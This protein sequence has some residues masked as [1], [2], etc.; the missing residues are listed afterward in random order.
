MFAFENQPAKDACQ[1]RYLVTADMSLL[2]DVQTRGNEGCLHLQGS[3]PKPAWRLS[4]AVPFCFCLFFKVTPCS[5]V[6]SSGDDRFSSCKYAPAGYNDYG[7]QNVVTIC[8]H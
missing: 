7:M 1:V 6:D 4:K 5:L 3:V 2:K 8:V